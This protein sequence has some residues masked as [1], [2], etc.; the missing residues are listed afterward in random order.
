MVQNNGIIYCRKSQGN[1]IKQEHS[2]N[3]QEQI[4]INF[5]KTNNIKIVKILKEIKSAYKENYR[6]L[7]DI[8]KYDSNI[9]LIIYCIDRFSRNV[10]LGK[11]LL[12]LAGNNNIKIFFIKE[13][14]IFNGNNT[15]KNIYNKILNGI[16]DAQSES[17][18]ISSRIKN[19]IKYKKSQGLYLGGYI[20]YG[21]NTIN[22]F[23][24]KK[25]VIN[26][27]ED[28]IINFILFCRKDSKK[29]IK[30]FNSLLK[31]I[32]IYNKPIILYDNENNTVKYMEGYMT[33]NN[34]AKLLNEYKIYN[35][36]IEWNGNM[37]R[38]IY[39]N[40]IN[41][42]K[43]YLLENNKKRK[44]NYTTDELISIFE[45]LEI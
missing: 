40:N 32:N 41:I 3:F 29:K 43:S 30:E 6:L 5:A 9:N 14:I 11:K 24:G 44:L 22:T 21:Y 12:D 35:R 17:E 8:I 31:L 20:P 28:N 18:K 4:C 39:K 34:I 7:N 19:I 42:N 2:L 37:I 13:K 33:F 15:N 25:L 16:K 1:D 10:T 38:T 23:N 26:N 45:P 36:G 27:Y